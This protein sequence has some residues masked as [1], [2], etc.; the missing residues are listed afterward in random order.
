MKYKLLI[1]LILSFAIILVA[2]SDGASTQTAQTNLSVSDT[3]QATTALLRETPDA[4]Q[5]YIDSFI[6]LGESTTYHLKS[7]GV[8][9]GGTN[10]HQVWSPKNGTVN[11]DTTIT[12]LK[13]IYPET[14]E[15]MTVAQ[16]SK[17]KQPK[18]IILTFG[19]NGAVTKVKRG[20][21]YFHSCYLSLINAIKENSPQTVIILQACFPI[22]Q[23]MDMSNYSINS[24]TLNEYITLIN[25]WSLELAESE[26]LGFL[27]T[28]ESLT[29][30][31]GFL[32]KEFDAGDGHHLTTAAYV[33]IL[34]YIRTHKDIKQ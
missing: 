24:Y 15:E 29:D 12:S 30:A 26:G 32:R 21:E 25:S 6:F 18:R 9:S 2:C 4:G 22:S 27:N 20:K 23:N 3:E 8:L 33:E 11:L 1:I 7:R 28:A 34:K 19:L 10:T 16:A 17:K 13:I 5:E 14:G 31:T